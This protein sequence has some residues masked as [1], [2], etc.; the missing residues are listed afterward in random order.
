MVHAAILRVVSQFETSGGRSSS[1]NRA[2]LLRSI[3]ILMAFAAASVHG[4]PQRVVFVDNRAPA[5]GAGTL[6]HPFATINN[7]ATR[8]AEIIFVAE[9]DQ[10]YRESVTLQR[11]QMLI[12]S[13]YGLDAVRTDLHQEFDAPPMP[14]AQGP[15]PR[16]EGTVTLA[17][18]NVVAGVTLAASGPAALS[19]PMP[20]GALLIYSTYIETSRGAVGIAIGGADFP[21]RFTGGGL[22]AGGGG[23]IAIYGGR[24]D[25]TFDGFPVGGNFTT[26]IDIRNRGGGA[27]VFRGRAAIKIGDASQAAVNIAQCAGRVDVEVPLQI[28]G[29]ARGLFIDRSTVKLSGDSTRVF[30]SDA[31]ALEI[32]DAAV[33]A[34]FTDVSAAGGEIGIVIDKLRGK[35]VIAGGTI[36]NARLHGIEVTQSA[37]VRMAKMTLADDGRGDRAK[38]D[39]SIEEKTNL[40]CRA[41]LYLRHVSGSEFENV[42]VS[43]GKQIGLNANNIE[44]VKFDGLEIRGVG[45]EVAEPAVLLNES[46]GNVQF[47]RCVLEDAF[48]GALV[49]TQQFNSAHVTFDRCSFSAPGRPAGAAHLITLRTSGIAKLDLELRNAQVY[50]NAASAIRA[51]ATGTS[52]MNLKIT[53]SR[54]ERFGRTALELTVGDQARVAFSMGRTVVNVPAA[55]DVPAIDIAVFGGASACAEMFGNQ[56]VNGG[57]VPAVRLSPSVS[58]CR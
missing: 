8:V 56:V 14:A 52:A 11:G 12:G 47:S 38:C 39:Q 25:V 53:D 49:L 35:L 29:H 24:G 5:G 45:D 51:D 23:G 20:A 37:G 33:D 58:A 19:A 44:N 2:L 42:A 43:G 46:K 48:D 4:A 26:A 6:E 55:V 30:T 41:A 50:D 7:Q 32:R 17:G 21:I 16:I 3:T 54:I 27:V 15:G 18:D 10:P 31:T 28:I 13:A 34:A 40:R 22:Q 36:R 57:A 9:S 1:E